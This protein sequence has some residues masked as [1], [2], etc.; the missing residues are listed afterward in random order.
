MTIYLSKLSTFQLKGD[1][2]LMRADVKSD[3]EVAVVSGATCDDASHGS[4]CNQLMSYLPPTDRIGYTFIVPHIPRANYTL[5]IPFSKY[6]HN[7]V[8]ISIQGRGYNYTGSYRG[9]T[10]NRR[11]SKVPYIIK[12]SHPSI[13][14]QYTLNYHAPAY[15]SQIL[16]PAVT[17][18]SNHYKFITPSNQ[19]YDNYATI[20]IRSDDVSGLRFDGGKIYKMDADIKTVTD[21]EALYTV[22]SLN[23]TT[24]IHR[25]SHVN[26]DVVFGLVLYGLDNDHSYG[27]PAGLDLGK[28]SDCLY[29]WRDHWQ[30]IFMIWIP[31][32]II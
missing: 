25:V 6:E 17:Q 16:I 20:I 2:Y 22:I 27:M 28:K 26:G 15:P 23:I 4:A 19:P 12:T 31:I 5:I 3:K 14:I 21:T 10:T 24:G 32:F 7:S 18:Y 8:R 11:S 1:D 29:P 30:T 13:I 9:Y